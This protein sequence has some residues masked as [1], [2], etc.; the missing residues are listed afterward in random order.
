[1]AN[2]P[3]QS[4]RTLAQRKADNKGVKH[5]TVRTGAGG[6]GLRKYNSKTGR[7]EL[8]RATNT[9]QGAR[10]SKPPVSRPPKVNVT[11][12][13]TVVKGNRGAGAEGPKRSVKQSTW[14]AIGNNPIGYLARGSSNR[15]I[16][17]KPSD[18]RGKKVQLRKTTRKDASGRD[19]YRWRSM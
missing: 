13:G 2:A 10:S 3:R 14:D 9:G 12:K 17:N 6:R 18:F 5:G 19:I 7:W 16:E 1:M 11:S 4:K 15:V 8:V